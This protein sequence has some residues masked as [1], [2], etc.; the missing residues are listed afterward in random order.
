MKIYL[1]TDH[2]GFEYKEFTK[3]YLKDKGFLVEDFGAKVLNNEDDY[4]D[5]IIPCIREFSKKTYGK[6]EQGKAIVFGG[7]GTG[8]AIAANKFKYI[9]VVVCNSDNLEIVKFARMHND[10][11]VLSVGAR[12][13]SKEFLVFAIETFLNT[14]FE[15]GRHSKRVLALDN[16]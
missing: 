6:F 5:F 4:T 7:S 12:F 13:I 1:A 11:N 16:L 14:E 3:K 9:R 2:A 10:V 8:E 15:A